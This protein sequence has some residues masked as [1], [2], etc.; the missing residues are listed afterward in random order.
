ISKF[1]LDEANAGNQGT[2]QR[3][4]TAAVVLTVLQKTEAGVEAV[5]KYAQADMLNA[6]LGKD[7]SQIGYGDFS[8]ALADIKSSPAFQDAV[9]QLAAANVISKPDVVAAGASGLEAPAPVAG[10]VG[11]KI[12]PSL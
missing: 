8:S 10:A 7:T 9:S 3:E 5:D 1:V 11:S 12:G 6:V 2:Y 4:E